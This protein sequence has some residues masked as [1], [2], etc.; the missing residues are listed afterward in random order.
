MYAGEKNDRKYWEQEDGDQAIWYSPDSNIKAW[1]IGHIDKLGT[2]E[3]DVSS[4]NELSTQCPDNKNNIWKYKTEN[5][6]WIETFKGAIKFEC[7]NEGLIG[8]KRLY[9]N[10]YLCLISL[11]NT[12]F[13][14]PK[15]TQKN[16]YA[17]NNRMFRNSC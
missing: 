15:T 9:M 12:I 13:R 6:K 7:D 2:R 14:K 10:Q 3:G 16:K 17:N 5:N 8:R 4:S 1:F 11:H